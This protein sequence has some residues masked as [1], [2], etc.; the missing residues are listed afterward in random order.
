MKNA[1]IH[2]RTLK[3]AVV[4]ADILSEQSRIYIYRRKTITVTEF[5]LDEFYDFNKE[6]LDGILKEEA[7][8]MDISGIIPS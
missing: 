3:N 5:T 4:D 1:S 7:D 2:N 6:I 8:K